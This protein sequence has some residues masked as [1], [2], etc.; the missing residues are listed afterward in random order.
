[1]LWEREIKKERK[2]QSFSLSSLESNKLR[3]EEGKKR[4]GRWENIRSREK[5]IVM[6]MGCQYKEEKSYFFS[7]P[8]AKKIH[9]NSIRKVETFKGE[10]EREREI[11]SEDKNRVLRKV[12]WYVKCCLL[13]ERL[14]SHSP[15]YTFLH[16]DILMLLFSDVCSSCCRVVIFLFQEGI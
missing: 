13:I 15:T 10:V 5:Q 8:T 3:S 2:I 1:M 9:N 16:W 12:S 11:S 7:M 14:A 6:D 4:R